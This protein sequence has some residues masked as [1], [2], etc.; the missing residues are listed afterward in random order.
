MS[1]LLGNDVS[2]LDV[3]LSQLD[4]RGVQIDRLA[5]MNKDSLDMSAED[6]LLIARTAARAS[7]THEGVVVVHGT[8]RLTITGHRILELEDPIGAPIVLTGAMRPYAP[9][10]HG[11]SAKSRGGVARRADLRVG[12]VFGHVQSASGFPRNRKGSTAGHFR[13]L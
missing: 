13:S 7:Q 9:Q 1:G 12:C 3:M 5:L 8:D 10:E 11:R 2:V 4:V 6:H